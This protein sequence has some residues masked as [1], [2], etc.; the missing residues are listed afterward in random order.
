MLQII[1]LTVRTSTFPFMNSRHEVPVGSLKMV[2]LIVEVMKF[3]NFDLTN[4]RFIY[5][6]SF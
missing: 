2:I 5:N 1:L 4:A 6:D 3:K